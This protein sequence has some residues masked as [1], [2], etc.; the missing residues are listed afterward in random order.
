MGKVKE[1]VVEPVN[2]YP[3]A[4]RQMPSISFFLFAEGLLV[5]EL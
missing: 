3:K 4:D 5:G 2:K 1:V